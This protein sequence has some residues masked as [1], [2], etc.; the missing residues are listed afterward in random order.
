M[1]KNLVFIASGG[2][3][4]SM[5]LGKYLSQ[6]IEDCYS[7]HEPDLFAGL[8]QLTFSRIKHFGFK[9]MILDRCLG[10]SGVRVLGQKLM[11]GEIT[12]SECFLRLREMRARYHSQISQGLIIES[13][14]SWWLFAN[15]INRIWPH[16][17]M[18]GIIRDPRTWIDSWKAHCPARRNNSS[19]DG[20]IQPLLTPESI[21]DTQWSPHWRNIGQTGRLAWDW[22]NVYRE[23]VN[24][25]NNSSQVRIFK[26]E[27]LFGSE[28]QSLDS[29]IQFITNHCNR[30]YRVLD[31]EIMKRAPVNSS[32]NTEN[33][34]QT[35]TAAEAQVVDQICGPIMKLFGYGTEP[36]WQKLLSSE[37]GK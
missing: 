37:T 20:F 17:K 7:E 29:F 24:A 9:H 27:D 22:L 23:L 19:H 31:L 28:S 11:K 8:S 10:R 6:V 4:G 36:E 14:Y 16:A 2:R 33:L 13:Y 12:D 18:A 5:F 3:T 21:N 32:A 25:Q 30:H 34:W 35:W 1:K 26:F 15:N